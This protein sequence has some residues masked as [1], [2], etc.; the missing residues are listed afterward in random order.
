MATIWIKKMTKSIELVEEFHEK[1]GHPN[2]ETINIHNE[3]LNE[4]RTKLISEEFI[5]FSDG[6]TERDPIEVL[7]GLL[8]LQYVLDGAFLALGFAKYKDAGLDEIHASNMSKLGKDGLPIYR[9]D[10]KIM[11]G[12]DYFKPD[13]A[14]IMALVDES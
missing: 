11:K 12:P 8:D 6:L 4:L 5:E 10:G 1:F 3:D 13:I 7:D 2:S 9:D 14:G